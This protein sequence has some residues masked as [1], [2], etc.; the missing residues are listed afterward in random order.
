MLD[1]AT[2]RDAGE[3]CL[4]QASMAK[5]FASEVA[6]R[7]CS[8]AIQIFGGLRLQPRISGRKNLPRCASGSDLRRHLGHPT[9]CHQSGTTPDFLTPA[10]SITQRSNPLIE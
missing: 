6:E 8:D 3:P 4:K 9:T 1:A 7:I 5:L 10:W 2:L